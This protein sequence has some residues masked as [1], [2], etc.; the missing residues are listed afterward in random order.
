MLEDLPWQTDA[1]GMPWGRG[2]AP[3]SRFRGAGGSGAPNLWR[4]ASRERHGDH[5][6]LIGSGGF[7]RRSIRAVLERVTGMHYD[8]LIALGSAVCRIAL[9]LIGAAFIG[10]M[11]Y[12]FCAFSPNDNLFN[13]GLGFVLTFALLRALSAV[14]RQEQRAEESGSV[15]YSPALAS[16]RWHETDAAGRCRANFAS[17]IGGHES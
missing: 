15:W 9:W 10:Q 2:A 17:G 1:T 5:A 13:L 6:K 14:Q 3:S 12:D 7:W 8:K 16:S 4:E 11:I